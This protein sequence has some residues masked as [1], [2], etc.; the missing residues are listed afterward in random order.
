MIFKLC[1]AV[2]LCVLLSSESGIGQQTFPDYNST[3]PYS[4][5]RT[6][7]AQKPITTES[8]MVSSAKTTKEVHQTTVYI[9]G[10]VRTLQSVDKQASPAGMDMVTPRVYDAFGREQFQY[11]PFASNSLQSGDVT[12]DGSFK[13]DAFRQQSTFSQNQF[14]GQS[15]YY[16]QTG[17]EQSPL[18]RATT[19]DPAG[20][21][22][23]GSSRGTSFQYLLNTAADNVQIWNIASAAG[24]LPI[25]AGSYPVGALNKIVTTDAQN[26]QTI[27]YKDNLEQVILKKVQISP[28]P[29][30]DHTG[31]LCTYYVYDDLGN[32]RFVITPQAVQQMNTVSSWT[33]SQPMADG[34]CYRFE[35]DARNRQAIKKLPGKGE[36][37]NVF[38]VAD[39]LV[40]MQDGNMRFSGQWLTTLYDQFDRVVATGMTSYSGSTSQLQQS[41]TS[42]NIALINSI[43][44]QQSSIT[45]SSPNTTGNYLASQIISLQPNF[46]TTSGGSFSASIGSMASM[47]TISAPLVNN[48]PIPPGAPFSVLTA[49]YYDDYSWVG[50]AGLPTSIDQSHTTDPTYF[51]TSYNSDP[52]YA[53]P[54]SQYASARGQITGMMA[55]VLPAA[56]Q[57]LYR[58]NFYDDRARVIQ[59]QS[60]NISGGKDIATRQYA[61]TGKVL[62]ELVQ[63]Q[64]L[65]NNAQTHIVLTTNSYDPMGRLLSVTKTINSTIGG[66][67][68]S[69]PAKT[70]VSNQYNELSQVKSKTLGNNLETLA[71]DYNIRGW[72]SGENRT[73]LTNQSTHYFGFE[74]GYDNPASSIAGTNYS[75]P[76]FNGNLSGMMWK[77]A[78]DQ[79]QRK[80]DFTYDPADRLAS[81]NFNQYTGSG[82]DK[83]AGLD[84][85]VSNLQYDANG[86]IGYMQQNGWK[87][88]GSVPIDKLTYAYNAN[89][90]QLSSITEDASIG[91]LDNHL[92]DFTDNN[93]TN[94]DY[95]Y[96]GNGN[97]TIDKNKRIT[98]ITYDFLNQPQQYSL[99]QSSGSTKGTVTFTYDANGIKLTK[100]VVDQTTSPSTTT[101]TTY[102]DNFVYQNDNLQF[103]THEEGRVRFATIYPAPGTSQNAFVFDYFVKD[104]QNNTRVILTEQVDVAQY[105]ATMEPDNR[106][107]EDALFT[108]I[109]NTSY[110]R[111]S[112]P[113]YPNDVSVTNPN[114]NVSLLDGT[115]Q[116]V[117]P[118][119]VLKVMSG[120]V[121]DVAVQYFYNNM[122]NTNTPSL[123]ASNIVGSLAAGL[124]PLTGGSHGTIANM[125]ASGSPV[126]MDLTSFLNTNNP[127]LSSKPQAYVN[128]ILLDNQFN[129]VGTYPQSG[130]APVGAFGTTS[131]GGLQPAIGYTGIPIT[132]SGY[133]FVYVSNATPG[134]NV[135]FDN[136]SVVTHSGPLLEENHY[137]PFGLTMAAISDQAMKSP[138]APNKYRY[139]GGSE[140]QNKEFSDGSGLELY[141]T[142]DR[143][144]DPQIGRWWQID[145]KPDHA[146][147]LYSANKNN[148]LLY[149]DPMGDTTIVDDIGYISARYGNDNLVFQRDGDHLLP[150]G[151]FGKTIDI[152]DILPNLMRSSALLSDVIN[153]LG[154]PLN[155]TAWVDMVLPNMHVMGHEIAGEWD[156]KNNEETIFGAAWKY[157]LANTVSMNGGH[158]S[159]KSNLMYFEDAAAVGN[160]HAGY[161]GIY[162]G[163]E[164][165][166]QFK[167]AGL[168]EMAKVGQH[169]WSEPIRLWQ[170]WWNIPPYGDQKRDYFW[171][172]QG[173]AQA[174][175]ELR[176]Q[177][178][179]LPD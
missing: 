179:Q 64:K 175:R 48:T 95:T 6:W 123:T 176:I 171:N 170:W 57:Y 85:S 177:D 88:G 43:S 49:T 74:V 44:A 67:N 73:Y 97:L 29:G 173:M 52:D 15:Y 164:P 24:S 112:A 98:G 18:N 136:M 19:I 28:T 146:L 77:S 2:V 116:K 148:P 141:A 53:Q 37:D 105:V 154:P 163:V 46:S 166:H 56:G 160:Y 137:Y 127:A 102:I 134:W 72:V 115:V 25:S 79:K 45:L 66:Q 70:I 103:L 144:L 42:Q 50:N 34:L 100:T 5:Q 60:I 151:E 167:W 129:Y 47:V 108:N 87:L 145:P 133:L 1:L 33:I 114:Q 121:V 135:Y 169:Y 158:T 130:A 106:T 111:S 124:F 26:H 162:A 140:L 139:N 14:P 10:L 65:G 104:Q 38:D 99:N 138:Y 89:S 62:R 71:Y 132:T 36:M 13:F 91:N 27:Q 78:G 17:F 113:G 147:S 31:W 142:L 152:S 54:I 16:G 90:N 149:T 128:W 81:A 131:G 11:L 122:S 159:F 107:K 22:W 59:T 3:I 30:Q 9:D 84:F 63:H 75:N 61:F 69:V 165:L 156:L 126:S 86:N 109:D 41:V 82:F 172:A 161:T 143:Q 157:D 39:R 120:D 178:F 118:G 68:Y 94:D 168:G 35:Y 40:F 155:E 125:T 8:E 83:S 20:N 23:V 93:Q 80:Y 117:G 7:L 150:I 32:L 4:F 12:N 119:I 101:T 96:D 51:N 21:S 55:A 58:E 110:P 76:Q 174:A 92:N 153:A